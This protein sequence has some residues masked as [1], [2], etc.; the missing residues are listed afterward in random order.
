MKGAHA[1]WT[2]TEA[3]G[4]STKVVTV[5]VT[6]NGTPPLSDTKT[7]TVVVD[8]VGADALTRSRISRATT[9]CLSLRPQRGTARRLEGRA[10]HCNPSSPRGVESTA[11][12]Y[13]QSSPW[14]NCV[15][16]LARK[17]SIKSATNLSWGFA[18]KLPATF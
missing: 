3:Q 15:Q 12:A 4:P 10:D 1:T 17:T 18:A 13:G 14:W 9:D 2:P 16:S 11:P 5:G 8:E 6:D 7:V